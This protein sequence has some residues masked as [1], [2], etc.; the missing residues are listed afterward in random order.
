MKSTFF[1]FLFLIAGSV[2][3]QEIAAFRGKVFLD[4]NQNLFFDKNEKGIAGICISNGK[5]VVQTNQKGE[6]TLQTESKETVFVIKPSG[7]S[8]PS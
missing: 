8:V 1:I 5:E 3:A 7:Y 4:E 6:W 2:T